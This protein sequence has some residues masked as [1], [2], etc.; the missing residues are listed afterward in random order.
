V[1]FFKGAPKGFAHSVVSVLQYE[2]A[3]AGDDI[4]VEGEAASAMFFVRKGTV[5]VITRAAGMVTTLPAGAYFGEIALL[6]GLLPPSALNN[7]RPVCTAT[8]QAQEPCE[9]F[10][11]RKEDFESILSLYPT[12]MSRMEEVAKIRMKNT[13]LAASN[14]SAGGST[15]TSLSTETRAAES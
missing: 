8:I 2:V 4:I 3:L 15:P 7:M 14:R 5:A 11:L 6:V 10:S 1:D 13:S 12:V 9:L